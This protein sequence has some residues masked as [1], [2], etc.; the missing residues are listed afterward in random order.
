MLGRERVLDVRD[1]FAVRRPAPGLGRTG[2]R[3]A[4]PEPVAVAAGLTR[5]RVGELPAQL[6]V[7]RDMP[8]H[9]L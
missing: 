5:A 2:C 3:G 7:G 6:M 8:E 1:E 9:D 4:Y